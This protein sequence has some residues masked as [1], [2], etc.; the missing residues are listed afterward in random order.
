VGFSQIDDNA[1]LLSYTIITASQA[2]L[3]ANPRLR[4]SAE[5]VGALPPP[6]P[7]SHRP[8]LDIKRPRLY[9]HRG[10]PLPLR[11]QAHLPGHRSCRT[12]LLPDNTSAHFISPRSS[13]S[14]CWPA[15]HTT[16]RRCLLPCLLHLAQRARRC[17]L[18]RPPHRCPLPHLPTASAPPDKL[19]S[20]SLPPPATSRAA[21]STSLVRCAAC[22]STARARA[23][24]HAHRCAPVEEVC[25]SAHQRAL[26]REACRR[27]LC[28]L[29]CRIDHEHERGRAWPTRGIRRQCVRARG[30]AGTGWPRRRRPDRLREKAKPTVRGG[31]LD[32]LQCRRACSSGE[33]RRVE[34]VTGA[35]KGTLRWGAG[36][37]GRGR[38]RRSEKGRR[39][40]GARHCRCARARA[41]P[42]LIVG[43]QLQHRAGG[44]G[45]GISVQRLNF[46]Y[47]TDDAEKHYYNDISEKSNVDI[48]F[49]RSPT[50]GVLQ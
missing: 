22:S 19:I 6:L 29:G 33:R 49:Q 23:H 17:R 42:A 39:G 50:L 27:E 43:V 16:P 7:S 28:K 24:R 38:P 26:V 48:L 45:D 14:G 44:D 4:P 12:V 32:V 31:S 13:A 37:G 36:G 3:V 40:R 20:A 30:G 1:W 10:I 46:D 2:P 9:L 25:A 21:F 35:V 41:M 34:E 18:P 15:Y 11:H 47:R 8:V 5:I